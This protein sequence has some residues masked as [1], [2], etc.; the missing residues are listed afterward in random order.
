MENKVEVKDAE[1]ESIYDLFI[2]ISRES[3]EAILKALMTPA[4]YISPKN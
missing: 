1:V 2:D 3:E 4:N